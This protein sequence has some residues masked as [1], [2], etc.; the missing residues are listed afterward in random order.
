M[1]FTFDLLT[2]SALGRREPHA[3]EPGEAFSLDPSGEQ[4]NF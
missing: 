2:Y 1:T 4:N 3:A